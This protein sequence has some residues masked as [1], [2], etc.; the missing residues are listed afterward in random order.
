MGE[1]RKET[2]AIIRGNGRKPGLP[3][4]IVEGPPSGIREIVFAGPFILRDGGKIPQGG[5]RRGFFR[6][7]DIYHR[8]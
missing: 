7:K 4:P 5:R 8:N 1:N 6:L 2:G 3:M